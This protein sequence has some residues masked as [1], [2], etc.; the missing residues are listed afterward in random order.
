MPN[1]LKVNTFGAALMGDE[2][3]KNFAMSIFAGVKAYI[4]E[5]PAEF[6]EWKQSEGNFDG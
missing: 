6:E 3:A 5:H 4:R 2:Q 1:V